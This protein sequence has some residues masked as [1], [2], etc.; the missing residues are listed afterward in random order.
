MNEKEVVKVEPPVLR[1][2][3]VGEIVLFNVGGTGELANNNASV[4]PAI[5][6]RVWGAGCVNLR[7]ITDGN[8][9]PWITSALYDKGEGFGHTWRFMN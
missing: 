4:L 7:V 3:R 5:V 9:M 6:T 8:S 2:P 1:D